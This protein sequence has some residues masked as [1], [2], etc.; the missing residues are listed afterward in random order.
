MASRSS[1]AQRITDAAGHNPCR[2]DALASQSLDNLLSK[3]AQRDTVTA[4]LGSS[5]ERQRGCSWLDLHPF[6]ATDLVKRDG[7]D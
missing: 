2:M 7:T 3:L 5:Q 6:P 1:W 4:E